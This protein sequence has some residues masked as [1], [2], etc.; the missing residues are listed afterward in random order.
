M[1]Q[2]LPRRSGPGGT[3]PA[4]RGSVFPSQGAGLHVHHHDDEKSNSLR[5]LTHFCNFACCQRSDS[6]IQQ[7][8]QRG[9]LRV[10]RC[11]QLTSTTHCYSVLHAAN[12]CPDKVIDTHILKPKLHFFI[13]KI[14]LVF[15]H[16]VT[17]AVNRSLTW[18]DQW[19]VQKF[20]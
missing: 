2:Q 19:T 8:Q 14:H 17:N 18:N 9:W 11:W 5:F 12:P 7:G 20:I 3:G 4:G 6:E 1:G 16:G 13:L 15:E 10:T